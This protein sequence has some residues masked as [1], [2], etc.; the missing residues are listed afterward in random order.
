MELVLELTCTFLD[1]QNCFVMDGAI[2]KHQVFIAQGGSLL[3]IRLFKV[4]TLLSKDT[5]EANKQE[6]L[7]SL[8][9]KAEVREPTTREEEKMASKRA[10][11]VRDALNNAIG[12]AE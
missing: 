11:T 3:M 4:N 9:G 10:K 1:A 6:K 5:K 2:G 12:V 7:P 8:E